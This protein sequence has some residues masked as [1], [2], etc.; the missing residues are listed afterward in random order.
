M[1]DH[2][3][4]DAVANLFADVTIEPM[5]DTGGWLTRDFGVLFLH[6]RIDVASDPSERL[7]DPEPVDCGP[8][9]RRHLESVRYRGHD[10]KVPPL[11]LHVAVNRRRGRNARADLIQSRL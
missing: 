2:A 9:A 11:H 5:V 4:A 8:H 3:D 6:A 7:D 1:I 10:I